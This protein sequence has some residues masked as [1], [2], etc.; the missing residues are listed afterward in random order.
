MPLAQPLPLN[1]F[2]IGCGEGGIGEEDLV[3]PKNR[4]IQLYPSYLQIEI[5]I[6]V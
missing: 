3:E 1:L 4:K 2:W 6:F 5:L